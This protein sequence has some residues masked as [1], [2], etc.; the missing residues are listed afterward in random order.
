VKAA[1]FWVAVGLFL[2]PVVVAA[3]EHDVVLSGVVS[4]AAERAA[5]IA[6]AGQGDGDLLAAVA[7]VDGFPS[8]CATPLTLLLT[9]PD[10]PL[11]PALDQAALAIETRPVLDSE[12]IALTHDGKAA[13]HYPGA[14]P[15]S[16]LMSIDRDRN[17][18]PDLIDRIAEALVTSRSTLLARLGYPWPAPEGER[19][20]V[21][22][23]DLGHGLEGFAVPRQDVAA[24]AGGSSAGRA[25]FIVLDAGLS[26]DRVMAAT[27]HQV[28]HL[29][30]L[31]AVERSSRA[32]S[33]ASASYLT[34]LATN[35]LPAH[36]AALRA[37]LA[38][39]GR[40]LASDSMLL[41]EGGLLWPLF[42]AER[43]GDPSI[44]RQIWHE[45]AA[46]GTDPLAATDLVLRR[47]GRTLQ[48]A[49]REYAAWNLF[50]GDRDDGQHYA[51][52]RSLPTAPLVEAPAGEPVRFEP[53]EPVEP[54]GS[55]V[56]GLPGD[57]KGGAIDIE[58]TADG[59]HP[60]ADLL[61]FYRSSGPQPVLVPITLDSSGGGRVSLP[62]ADVR[63]TWIVMRNDALPGGGSTRF[64]ARALPDPYAPFDLASF[65]AAATGPSILLEWTTASEKGLMAWN[66][67]RAET[68]GGPY[69]RLNS[70]AVPA[71]GDTATDTGYIFV[72]EMAV[73]GRRYY[74]LLEGLTTLGLPQ[75]SHVVSGRIVPG[76]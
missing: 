66:I 34:L 12:R 65:T 28:A 52:G 7:G 21:F 68:P 72:D 13:I 10:A 59:G 60:G 9:R 42:L 19:L 3:E 31:S 51:A 58:V 44:V 73:P 46:Q 57:G 39:T 48:D 25:P 27:L 32:W 37:R 16:G 11:P 1:R 74:Y 18:V 43:A 17:G 5:A 23:V 63:E 67:Y 47:S 8:A 53:A 4:R 38:S 22:V 55:A 26:S 24:P 71:M 62:W 70:V 33:E 6:A 2:V 35:D 15:S 49:L 40:G 29:S 56:F 76:R 54:L 36:E 69:T 41:M 64:E 50:T 61:V 45:M 14:S 75:R 20:E 30:L